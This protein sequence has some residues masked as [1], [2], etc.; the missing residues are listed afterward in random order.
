MCG[1]LLLKFWKLYQKNKTVKNY[2]F[3]K[4]AA[5]QIDFLANDFINVLTAV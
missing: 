2:V 1:D 3:L 5:L 4:L